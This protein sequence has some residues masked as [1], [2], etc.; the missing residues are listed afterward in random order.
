MSDVELAR[1]ARRV[2][3]FW[4]GPAPGQ[5]RDVWFKRDPVFD[6]LIRA[7]F[8]EL[9]G[10]AAAGMC[11]AMAAD[12]KGSLALIVVLD[13][14]S[15]NLYRD[16]PQAFACDGRALAL[17]RQALDRGFDRGL[18][19]VERVFFYLPFEH[20][21]D[22]AVQ[23][24]S[25]ALFATIPDERTQRFA[26]RHQEIIERFGRFPHRNAVLGRDTTPEEHAFLQ[27]PDSSF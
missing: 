14:F 24:E 21:E 15:R 25:V 20:C 11:D 26:R 17:A 7:R 5:K 8:L 6:S 22:L 4:F 18:P 19:D 3:D 2:L 27:E 9:H 23:A 12:A 1:E 16:S 10:R 13:Q